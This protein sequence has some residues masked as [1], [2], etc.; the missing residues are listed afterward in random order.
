MPPKRVRSTSSSS[1]IKLN[2]KM[3][4]DMNKIN[5]MINEHNSLITDYF[6][7]IIK[8]NKTNK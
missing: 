3:L 6:K 4:E 7:R 1:S 5:Q 8:R 2:K